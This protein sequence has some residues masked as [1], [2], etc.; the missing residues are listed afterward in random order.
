MNKR[1]KIL[2]SALLF[3]VVLFFIIV[4]VVRFTMGQDAINVGKGMIKQIMGQEVAMDQELEENTATAYEGEIEID[5][6]IKGFEEIGKS[7][8]YEATSN[9]VFILKGVA[10]LDANGDGLMDLFVP[11]SGRPVARPHDKNGVLDL[12]GRVDAKA[13]ALFLN[14]GNDSKG[15]PI[16]KTVAELLEDKGKQTHLREEL[17]IENKYTPRTSL[18]ESPLGPGRISQG[19]MVADFNGDGRVDI[20]V[21]NGHY[22]APFNVPGFGLRVYPGANHLGR[23]DK[24]D[25]EYIETNI[26]PFLHG[27]LKDGKDLSFSG[28]PEGMNTLFINM[29]DKDQ[30]GIPEWKNMTEEVGMTTNYNST[31]GAVTD[32]DRDGDLDV[33]VGN[34]VD[35]DYWGFG[36][37]RFPGNR[38][39]LW[40]NQLKETGE[41]KFVE[42][43]RDMGVSGE[44]DLGIIDCSIPLPNGEILEDPANLKLKGKQIG[45]NATHSWAVLCPDLNDDGYP[46]LMVANDVPNK[47]EVYMNNGGKSYTYLKEFDEDKYIGCWMGLTYADLNQDG[48]EDV[49]VPNCGSATFSVRNTTLFIT[50]KSDLNVTTYCQINGIENKTTLSH[51]MLNISEDGVEDVSKNVNVQ[52]NP[53]TAPDVSSRNNMHPIAHKVFDKDKYSSTMAGLEFSWCPSFFDVEND[54]DLDIYF[55]GALNRGNDNFIGDWSGGVGR[56]LVNSSTPGNFN[57]EDRTLEYRLFDIADIDYDQTPPRRKSPGTGWHKEDYVYFTD[58]DS[59]S[60]QGFEVSQ[61]SVIKDI[62]RMHESSSG[63]VTADL[64]NDGKVDMVVPHTA[65]YNSLSPDAR[66]LKVELMGKALALPPPN[67]I[68]KAMTTFEDGPLFVYINKEDSGNNWVKIQLDNTGS[69]NKYGIGAKVRINDKIEIDYLNGGRNLSSTF[70]NLH[71]GLGTDDI[72]TI[73]IIWPDGNQEEQTFTLD[74]S[75]NNKTLKLSR[76]SNAVSL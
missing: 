10:T 31:C 48:K 55:V 41:F 63:S 65:G 53:L 54:G 6:S 14:Q 44:C 29:G 22:G 74:P 3:L 21:L 51:L 33:F 19:A 25:T 58:R 37:L 16:Y 40:V 24:K 68:V 15:N 71:V 60:G 38:N 5:E 67:K 13:C 26:P 49:L 45:E 72:K 61:S 1:V 59:Y 56:M 69:Y 47:L 2:I 50:E 66:N 20:L 34:F 73:S 52:Y 4:Q 7:L 32:I 36:A 9:N 57:F 70:E 27:D 35:P 76:E 42:V 11:H 64:N 18:D 75:M 23:M 12:E 17:L 39:T 28:E 30:D 8:G 62:F 43:G 46:D